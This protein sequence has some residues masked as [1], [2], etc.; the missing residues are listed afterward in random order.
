MN[1]SARFRFLEFYHIKF[2]RCAKKTVSDADGF[3]E[4]YI[5]DRHDRSGEEYSFLLGYYAHLL[6]DSLYSDF[7][8]GTERV[9]AQW[10]RVCEALDLSDT[11]IREK[12]WDSLKQIVPKEVRLREIHTLEAVHLE[13]N[14]DSAYLTEIIP[15]GDFPDYLE[16]MPGKNILRKIGIMGYIPAVTTDPAE[17]LFLTDEEYSLYI[18]ATADMIAGRFLR[19]GLL[20]DKT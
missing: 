6:A 17:H 12:T 19:M 5:V 9:E 7:V 3:A 8:R 18:S 16:F 13:K 11:D 2:N 4:E 1:I 14:P 20:N 10:K 15:L